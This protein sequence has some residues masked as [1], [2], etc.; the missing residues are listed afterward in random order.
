LNDQNI[1]VGK[2]IMSR[3]KK[4][5][6]I[7]LENALDIESFAACLGK[8]AAQIEKMVGDPDTGAAGTKAI[9][10]ALAR[11]MEQTFSKPNGWMD[12][13]GE[14]GASFDLFGES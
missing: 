8:D 9:S 13:E 5:Q 11:V 12:T 6:E 7:M 14:G 2:E 3:W 4:A 10:D 1:L